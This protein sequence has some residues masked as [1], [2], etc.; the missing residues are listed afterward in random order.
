LPS[1]DSSDSSEKPESPPDDHKEQA[2]FSPAQQAESENRQPEAKPEDGPELSNDAAEPSPEK[3]EK[4]N[5]PDS[6]KKE[7]PQI[8]AGPEQKLYKKAPDEAARSEQ[9]KEDGAAKNV[10]A[11]KQIVGQN[12]DPAV[13]K[14]KEKEKIEA[15]NSEMGQFNVVKGDKN[16]FA[17]KLNQ[18]HKV[19][20]RHAQF[21][22][23]KLSNY[24]NGDKNIIAENVINLLSPEG[25]RAYEERSYLEY[26]TEMVDRDASIPD[27]VS[28][29]L[30]AKADILQNERVLLINCI[31]HRIAKAAAY[32]VIDKTISFNIGPR[33]LLNFDRIEKDNFEL[34]IYLLLNKKV[35]T[36]LPTA[37][38]ADATTNKAQK[39]L[40]TLYSN[41][42]SYKEI[43]GELKDNELVLICL[44]DSEKA[45]KWLS[46]ESSEIHSILWKIPFLRHLLRPGFSDQFLDLEQRILQQ[47]ALGRWSK[48]EGDFCRQVKSYIKNGSLIEQ[49]ESRDVAV[50]PASEDLCFDDDKPVH[51]TVLYTATFYSDLNPNEFD[52]VVSTLLGSQTMTITQIVDQRGEDGASRQ[53]EVRKEKPLIQVWR[54]SSDRILR[55]CKLITSK[56]SNRVIVFADA[57]QRDSFKQYLEEEYGL[58]LQNKFTLV[59]ES[60]LLF[61][62]SEKIAKSVIRLILD[63]ATT[64]PDYYGRDWILAIVTRVR[65]YF[66]SAPQV[67]DDPM[68]QLLGKPGGLKTESQA[69]KRLSD[70]MRDMLDSPHL[71]QMVDGVLEQLMGAGVHDSVL[72]I[73]KNLRFVP[74]FDEF[75]WMKQL[76]DRGNETVRLQ[77]YIYL[78]TEMRRMDKQVYQIMRR[79]AGWLPAADGDPQ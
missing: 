59:Q 11:P 46:D 2:E 26:T 21:V 68:L 3:D 16:I 42:S 39:F 5:Q 28:D 43:K 79:I 29:D 44:I 38:I 53:V 27:F 66:D 60:G 62:A 36:D 6:P 37:I 7:S 32:A 54:E 19:N 63:M 77:T 50:R 52:R 23:A 64:Y 45:D 22:N 17:E 12:P 61:D 70:L 20:A 1:I 51:N 30:E 34:T 9:A 10:N 69:Y 24:V 25:N 49:I 78:Y 14:K 48:D 40:D 71:S 73:V 74:E 65:T 8:M 33:R 75:Y 18:I 67:S 41:W 58:F 47:R 76:L 31:D 15:I 56:D 72:S 55:E 4:I 57:G 35:D 13:I